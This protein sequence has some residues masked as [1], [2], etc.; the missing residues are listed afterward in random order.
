M[1]TKDGKNKKSKVPVKF[2]ELSF[3]EQKNIAIMIGDCLKSNHLGDIPI[4]ITREDFYEFE[5]FAKY[6]TILRIEK[7]LPS[8]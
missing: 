5:K 4:L 3:A 6:T 1:D 2:G 8:Y 7:K